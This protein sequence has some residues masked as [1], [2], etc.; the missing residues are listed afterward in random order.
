MEPVWKS[1][2]RW[3]FFGLPFTFTKYTLTKEKILVDV[4]FLKSRQ[5]EIRLY[6]VA[7]IILTR[8]LGQR[9]FGLG[10][11]TL[12]TSDRTLPTLDIINVRDSY[13]VKEMI[14]SMV[15]DERVRKKVSTR[16]LFTDP[17][18]EDDTSN[19]SDEYDDLDN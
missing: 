11:I 18:E 6:R 3:L 16:E 14:S 19:D 9:I 5:D 4:E 2:K 8:S 10:T 12:K 15:E 1:K 17:T 13:N 7:D